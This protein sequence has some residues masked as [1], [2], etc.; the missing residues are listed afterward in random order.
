MFY[1]FQWEDK[2]KLHHRCESRTPRTQ[3]E[4]ADKSLNSPTF[5]LDTAAMTNWILLFFF[6]SKIDSERP[7][8]ARYVF[9]TLWWIKSSRWL[10]WVWLTVWNVPWISP[11]LPSVLKW[12]ELSCFVYIAQ[13]A[14][15]LL[16]P[17]MLNYFPPNYHI[18]C[19]HLPL[20]CEYSITALAV[21][22][23]LHA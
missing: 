7:I 12:P 6:G 19:H 23:K 9:T 18:Y 21:R 8:L 10:K 17:P 15:M 1:S 2:G 13:N 22:I 14:K 4:P 16:H 5:P 20:T 11:H 3:M